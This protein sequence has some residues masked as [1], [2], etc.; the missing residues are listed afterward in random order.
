M[1]LLLLL[2]LSH[3]AGALVVEVGAG[4]CHLG[5]ERWGAGVAHLASVQPLDTGAGR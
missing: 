5:A 1:L 2:P 4:C 3:V